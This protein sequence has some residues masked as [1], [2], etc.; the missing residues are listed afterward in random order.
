MCFANCH[1]GLVFLPSPAKFCGGFVYDYDQLCFFHLQKDVG[2]RS[3]LE[4]SSFF[5]P[6]SKSALLPIIAAAVTCRIT[7]R[8]VLSGL[9][10]RKIRSSPIRLLSIRETLINPIVIFA[11]VPCQST[12]YTLFGRHKTSPNTTSRGNHE[13][14]ERVMIDQSSAWSPLDPLWSLS[15]LTVINWSIC[16]EVLLLHSL[17]LSTNI[18]R[19]TLHFNENFLLD[20][21]A[22]K[23]PFVC[24]LWDPAKPSQFPPGPWYPASLVAGHLTGGRAGRFLKIWWI[25]RKICLKKTLQAFP[26]WIFTESSGSKKKIKKRQSLTTQQAKATH[27]CQSS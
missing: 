17:R 15:G 18:T 26:Q 24:F 23:L 1:K 7:R 4:L 20:S 13:T 16:I 3:R 25:R 21:E 11:G 22:L 10:R 9:M 19:K 27:G 2:F 8:F 14:T 6:P 12:F 5:L